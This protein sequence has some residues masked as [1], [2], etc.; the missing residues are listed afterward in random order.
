MTGSEKSASAND[1]VDFNGGTVISK[2]G[3]EV[4]ITEDMVRKAIRE[5]DPETFKDGAVKDSGKH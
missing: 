2:D 3:R 4:K 5:L 1:N